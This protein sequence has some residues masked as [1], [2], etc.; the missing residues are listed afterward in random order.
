MP[1]RP[2]TS[3]VTAFAG[4]VKP[5]GPDIVREVCRDFRLSGDSGRPLPAPSRDASGRRR[6]PDLAFPP[7]RLNCLISGSRDNHPNK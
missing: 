2:R 6:G 5:I 4:D 1:H 7:V 3:I